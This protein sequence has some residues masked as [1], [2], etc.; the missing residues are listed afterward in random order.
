MERKLEKRD[1]FSLEDIKKLIWENDLSDLNTF[2]VLNGGTGTGKT[3]SVMRQIKDELATKLQHTQ[4]LLVVESRTA[5]VRQL[6][7]NYND[8]IERINGIDVCQR[9]GFMHMLERNSVQYDWIII[10]ECHGLFSEASFAEDA[11]TIIS[12][13]RD[14]REKQHIIFVTA[15]D[16]YFEDLATKYFG[17]DY[18]FIYLFPNFTH[19]IS[20]TYVKEIQFIKTNRVEK[21]IE[22]FLSQNQDKKGIIFLKKAS[23]TKDWFFRTSNNSAMVVSQSCDTTASLTIKQEEEV[24]RREIDISKGQAGLTIADLCEMWD[25]ARARQGLEPIRQAIDNERFPVDIN[26]IFATDTLQEGISIKSTIDFII[27]EGYTEVEVRQKLGRYRGNLPLLYIIFNP[28]A[29]KHYVQ[30]KLDT[31]HALWELQQAGRQS[32][33]AEAYGRQQAGKVK[34]LYVKK[35]LNPNTGEPYYEVNEPAYLDVKR[36]F[37]FYLQ[38]ESHFEETVLQNYTYPLLEGSP[39]ILKYD[40]IRDFNF[41]SQILDIAQKWK[42]I[43]LKGPAQEQ[44]IQDLN[45]AG[46]TDKTRHQISSFTKACNLL[47]ENGISFS[48]KQATKTDISNWPQYLSTPREKFKIIT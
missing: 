35:K 36:E 12:W 23:D 5:T 25:L 8:V 40:E 15:N 28:V 1:T 34:T 11:E 3:Y 44:L 2:I 27:I 19:Y 4:K 10:D 45:E 47:R 22:A 41:K 42:G 18:H 16:E 46:I 43:P 31:F 37:H 6:D 13:I 32:E 39:R 20:N 30:D 17:K 38:L 33:L 14:R 29:A 9:L 21:V 48:E 7:T 26:W 24:K